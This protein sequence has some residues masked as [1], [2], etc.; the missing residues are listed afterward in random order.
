M[1]SLEPYFFDNNGSPSSAVPNFTAG[2]GLVV[3]QS[4]LDTSISISEPIWDVQCHALKSNGKTIGLFKGPVDTNIRYVFT[5]YQPDQGECPLMPLQCE[6]L[7]PMDYDIQVSFGTYPI[8]EV[9][10]YVTNGI[11]LKFPE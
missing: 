6:W 7:H 9:W 8:L 10:N 4:E 5:L 2:N 1:S 11:L 3:T